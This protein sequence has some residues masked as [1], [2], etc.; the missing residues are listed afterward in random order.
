MG[1]HVAIGQYVSVN[2]LGY[3]D[4]LYQAVKLVIQ[5]LYTGFHSKL[6]D[7]KEGV[8]GDDPLIS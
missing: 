1:V 4:R 6:Y 5:I 2:Q 8:I 3:I 7:S